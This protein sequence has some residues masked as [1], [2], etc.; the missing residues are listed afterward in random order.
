MYIIVLDTNIILD[1]IK[2]KVD[3]FQ[4]LKRICNFQYNLAILDKTLEEL[5]NKKNSKLAFAL[6]KKYKLKI[7][8]TKQGYVDSI[9]ANLNKN[10]IIATND[11][12]LKKLLKN[13]P[14]ITLRQK[15]YLMIE[16][17]L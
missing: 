10:Y 15:K 2:F 12:G 5:K 17:V 8:K 9:L 7:I 1:I 4:E 11:Q 14:Y 6:I 3:I 13:K 16:N